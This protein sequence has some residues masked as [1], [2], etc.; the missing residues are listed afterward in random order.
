VTTNSVARACSRARHRPRRVAATT[1][2]LSPPPLSHR[3]ARP[4]LEAPFALPGLDRQATATLLLALAIFAFILLPT[5]VCGRPAHISPGEL[6]LAQ[7]RAQ[8]RRLKAADRLRVAARAARARL[9]I[10]S[11]TP[12]LD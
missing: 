5:L 7:A 8:E 10:W 4:P 1:A 3:A 12:H 2:P 11:S 9:A 6:V